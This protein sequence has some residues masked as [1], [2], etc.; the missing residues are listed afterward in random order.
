MAKFSFAG[1]AIGVT[2]P[3]ALSVGCV[4]DRFGIEPSEPMP[5]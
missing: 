2:D 5:T 4:S 1:P 3:K